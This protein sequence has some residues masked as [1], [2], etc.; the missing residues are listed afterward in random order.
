[1]WCIPPKQ[2]AEFVCHME[3]VLDVYQRSSNPKRP[4]VCMDETFKQLIGETREPLP[5]APGRVERF[6]HVY[7]RNGVASLF[8]AFE[9]LTGW[10]HVTV[11]DH[12]RR[13]E[14]ASFVKS[15]VDDRYKHA[16][17]IVLV[18][19]QLN[20]HSAASLYEAFAPEEAKRIAAKL[21]IHH[22]PKHGSWLNMAEIELSA[23]GRQ[24]L[25]RRIAN[26]EK[27]VAS[28]RAWEQARNAA[29]RKVNWQFTTADARIKLHRLYPSIE[30]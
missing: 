4:V 20:T 6:D 24:C 23:L 1:M 8:L 26:Q 28:I 11:T 10:R 22:T 17:K 27:L 9:P 7:V 12:R 29:S 14:W 2:S 5:P 13:L 19:D 3:D 30:G 18:M 16:E 15:L 25:S 21:E